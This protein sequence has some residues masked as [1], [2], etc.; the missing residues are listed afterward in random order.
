MV[1]K[2]IDSVLLCAHSLMGRENSKPKICPYFHS[3]ICIMS[4]KPA[5]IYR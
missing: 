3:E 2:H 1:V 4:E 5:G